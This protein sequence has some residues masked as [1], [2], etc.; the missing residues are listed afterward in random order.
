MNN[1]SRVTNT[2]RMIDSTLEEE[3][4]LRVGFVIFQFCIF[5]TRERSKIKLKYI[6]TM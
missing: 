3:F 4:V 5:E 6:D 2:T 1:H